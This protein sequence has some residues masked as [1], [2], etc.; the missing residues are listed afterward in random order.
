MRG[1]EVEAV[2][3]EN[4]EEFFEAGFSLHSLENSVFPHEHE[5]SFAGD[6]DDFLR[7]GSPPYCEPD[8]VCE[9]HDFVDSDSSSVS[10][11][12]TLFAS[13]G[14]VEFVFLFFCSDSGNPDVLEHIL[15]DIYF[16][17]IGFVFFDTV[18]TIAS[19]KSLC[20]DDIKS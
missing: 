18:R 6:V 13:F 10:G 12:P 17:R 16:A 2:L 1:R 7:S 11:H 19:D 5:I 15:D 20:Y 14:A 9:V 3:L 4:L 8:I